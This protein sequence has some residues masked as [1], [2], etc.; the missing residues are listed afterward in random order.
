MPVGVGPSGGGLSRRW[1][2]S[3][4]LV[5]QIGDQ[6]GPAGLVPGT[7]A[8]AG[9]AIKIFMKQYQIAEHWVILEQRAVVE[10]RPLAILIALKQPDQPL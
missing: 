8:A 3:R 4:Q 6:P 1:A 2:S 9:I 7:E 10:D 5:N